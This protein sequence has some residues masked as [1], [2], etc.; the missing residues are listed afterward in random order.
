M[1]SRLSCRPPQPAPQ[2][3]PVDV[4][5]VAH[6]KRV[7]A[8]EL[9]DTWCSAAGVQMTLAVLGLAIGSAARALIIAVAPSTTPSV[10]GDSPMSDSALPVSSAAGVPRAALGGEASVELLEGGQ[11]VVKVPAGASLAPVSQGAELTS[12]PDAA[13]GLRVHPE[14]SPAPVPAQWALMRG[15]V[16]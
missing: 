10:I 15:T 16:S 5:I 8:H 3:V 1:P 9:K 13:T 14:M 4:D 2:R 6:P 12:G 7:F 11:A